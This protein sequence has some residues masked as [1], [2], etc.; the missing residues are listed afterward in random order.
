MFSH[1]SNKNCRREARES[2]TSR[3]SVKGISI[4]MLNSH[5]LLTFVF[6]DNF[7]IS[8]RQEESKKR[9]LQASPDYI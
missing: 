2:D 5:L 6:L 1:G 4:K 3:C 9:K 8:H 7:F